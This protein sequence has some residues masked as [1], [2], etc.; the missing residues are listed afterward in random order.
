MQLPVSLLALVASILSTSTCQ[1]RPVGGPRDLVARDLL[2]E[3]D[4]TGT[5]APR[6]QNLLDDDGYRLQPVSNLIS[7][8]PKI[9]SPVKGQQWYEGQQVQV[10]CGTAPP[11]DP[12]QIPQQANITLGFLSAVRPG[13][14]LDIANPLA[15]VNLYEEP[16]QVTLTLPT[17][18]TTRDSYL[19]ILGSSGNTS[20]LFTITGTG[21]Q[22][23]GV[24]QQSTTVR[25]IEARPITYVI[26]GDTTVIGGPD[27][28][29]IQT[30]VTSPTDGPQGDG[31]SDEPTAAAQTPSVLFTL[32]SS[33]IVAP[34][35]SPSPSSATASSAESAPTAAAASDDPVAP[36]SAATSL[37]HRRGVVFASTML[38]II[39]AMS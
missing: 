6:S 18:L 8:Y 13:F 35:A 25:Q 11:Y 19:L 30:S 39:V 38:A 16:Y 36:S 5:G 29:Q 3:T 17:N 4:A 1:A 2:L 23:E 34:V 7:Y 28:G 24:E 9:T 10:A 33:V 26:G 20:P 37:T 15:T 31:T 21:P 22:D 14:N 12:S 32:A 27:R